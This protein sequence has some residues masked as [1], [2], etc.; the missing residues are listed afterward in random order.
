V[1][2]ESVTDVYEE[3]KVGGSYTVLGMMVAGL[4]CVP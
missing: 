2:L 3:E 4:Q 1:Y